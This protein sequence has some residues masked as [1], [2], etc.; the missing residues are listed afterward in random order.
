[1]QCP[2]RGTSSQK[3]QARLPW[4]RARGDSKLGANLRL[5]KPSLRCMP[6]I[7]A[8]PAIGGGKVGADD[9]VAPVDLL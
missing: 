7:A 2:V 8:S 6:V 5:V 9:W 1:M 4:R 3:L